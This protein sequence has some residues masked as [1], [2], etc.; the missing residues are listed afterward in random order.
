MGCFKMYIVVK[1]PYHHHHPI[2]HPQHPG[3]SLCPAGCCSIDRIHWHCLSGLC[4]FNFTASLILHSH[5][6]VIIF[7]SPSVILCLLSY[8]F[9]RCV[10]W[11]PS[12]ILY[13]RVLPVSSTCV[14]VSSQLKQHILYAHRTSLFHVVEITEISIWAFSDRSQSV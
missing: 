9:S 8:V 2:P 12:L 7:T 4:V 10:C 11:A 14:C 6:L 1:K 3:I 5:G 13:P